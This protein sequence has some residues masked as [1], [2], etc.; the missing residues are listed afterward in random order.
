MGV[1][2]E[3]AKVSSSGNDAFSDGG[4]VTG[5]YVAATATAGSVQLKDGSG[6][7][8]ELDVDTAASDEGIMIP[9]P[10][11]IEFDSAVHVVFSNVTS[12]TVFRRAG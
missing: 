12:V 1:K 3:A 2:T 9:I 4:M 7:S 8:T 10:G 6:G 5:L 11:E